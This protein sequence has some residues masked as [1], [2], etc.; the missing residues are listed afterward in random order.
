[1]STITN[2]QINEKLNSILNLLESMDSRITA[3]ETSSSKKSVSATKST[4]KKTASSKKSTKKSAPSQAQLDARKAWGEAQHARAEARKELFSII[5]TPEY[6][7]EW[8]KWQK[9][10]AYK[11]SKGAERKALNKERHAQI[12]AKLSK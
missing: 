3:L 11:E 5:E 7:K 10:K 6:K 8:A 1:M 9:T 2:K 4:S 12:V